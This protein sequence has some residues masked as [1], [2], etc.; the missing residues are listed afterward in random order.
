MAVDLEKSSLPINVD[1]T[2]VLSGKTINLGLI[3]PISK[4]KDFSSE[5]I[6]GGQ[7]AVNEINASG[8]ILGKQLHLIPADDAAESGFAAD[9]AQKLTSK[10]KVAGLIGPTSS[11]RFIKVVNEV[12]AENPVVAISPSATSVEVT[13]LEDND[14]AF[15]TAASDALQGKTAAI[16]SSQN[17]GHK[18]AAI[19]YLN[20]VYGKGLADEFKKNFEQS[21]G[22][23]VGEAYYSPLVNLRDYDVSPKVAEILESKPNVLYLVSN[24]IDIIDISHQLDSAQVFKDHRPA[25]IGSDAMRGDNVLE[26]ASLP[27]LDGMYGTSVKSLKE[28]SFEEKFEK[29]YGKRPEYEETADVYDIVYLFA[30]AMIQGNTTDAT[31]LAEHIRA[32]SHTGKKVK[33]KD[34]TEV[35]KL[36][37]AGKDIDYDGVNSSLDFDKNGD[38]PDREYQIWQLKN[39]RFNDNIARIKMK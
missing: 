29:T 31:A 16:Y 35:R 7:L 27:A 11:S 19:F 23:I 18:T 5:L 2:L 39:G 36:L 6:Q 1:S 14:M 17:L 22:K 38:V 3:L 15:R 26:K 34:L 33:A 12:I 21:G 37:K 25:I 32:V 24:S 13:T 30:L 4:F 8:Y 10:Y 9:K 20:N 28:T